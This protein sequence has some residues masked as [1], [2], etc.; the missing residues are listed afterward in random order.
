LAGKSFS[1]L[2]EQ[3]EYLRHW[4]ATVADLRI[5]G[6][7]KKQVKKQFEEVERL[8]LRPL[9]A[10]RFPCFQEGQRKVSRDAHVEVDKAYYSV[11]PEYLGHTVWARYDARL[12]RLFDL[13]F[14]QIAIHSRVEPGRFST[15]P[16]HIASEKISG[17]EKGA[18][19]LLGRIDSIGPQAALWARAVMAERGIQGVRV[20]QG[21]LALWRRTSSAALD[22]ACGLAT[23]HGIYRLRGIRELLKHPVQQETFEFMEQHPLIREMEEYGKYAP[24]CFRKEDGA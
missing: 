9:P 11:P 14:Q 12:V 8:A 19:Y 15:Q 24:V 22:T 3:N 20:L 17:V 6:T 23:G 10:E 13:R 2:A 7:T 18:E 16:A 4:E 21:L 5:H 1:S